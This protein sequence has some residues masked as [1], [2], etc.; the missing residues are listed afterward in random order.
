LGGGERMKQGVQGASGGPVR[1]I[2]VPRPVAEPTEVLVRTVASII[3]PGTERAVTALAR[4]NVLSKAR[5]RPDLVRQVVRRARTDGV[6]DTAKKVRRRLGGDIPLG[7][8]AAGIALE[9]GEHV[10][11]ISPGQLVATGGAGKA[12]HAEYQAVP[13]LLCVPVPQGVVAED[14][15]FATIGAIALHGLR[16]AELGAGSRVV[17]IGLGLVGQLAVRLALASGCEVT[18]IDVSPFSANL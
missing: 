9:V 4:S 13:G 6:L 8:S 14:A 18:G 1:I 17:V 7:Y 12:N 10:S 15:A 2:D 3:S 16:L 11:G 5:A